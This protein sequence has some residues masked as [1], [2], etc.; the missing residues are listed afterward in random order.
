MICYTQYLKCTILYNPGPI[1]YNSGIFSDNL[2]IFSDTL[3]FFYRI[4]LKY[5]PDFIK[6]PNRLVWATAKSIYELH[7]VL[8]KLIK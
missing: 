4:S 7:F 2:G 1:I 5:C 8:R 6:M 3:R